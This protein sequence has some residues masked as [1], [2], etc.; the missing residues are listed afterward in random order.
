MSLGEWSLGMSVSERV[1]MSEFKNV[2]DFTLALR[3]GPMVSHHFSH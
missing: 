2:A 1:A 3:V